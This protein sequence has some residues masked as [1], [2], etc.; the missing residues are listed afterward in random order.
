MMGSEYPTDR[1]SG[2]SPRL[3]GETAPDQ[4]EPQNVWIPLLGALGGG[5]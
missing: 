4:A 5:E 3:D 1:H 2:G